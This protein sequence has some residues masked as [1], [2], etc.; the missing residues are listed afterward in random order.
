MRTLGKGVSRVGHG[1]GGKRQD[2]VQTF[3][4]PIG[5]HSAL[6]PSPPSLRSATSPKGRGKGVDEAAAGALPL[7]G[8]VPSAHTGERGLRGRLRC[9]REKTVP[10][11]T[12]LFPLGTPSAM[13]TPQSRSRSTAP[14]RGAPRAWTKPPQGA[15]PLRG[16][17]QCAHWGKGSPESDTVQ[18]GKD[19]TQCRHFFFPS[20]VTRHWHPLRPRCARPPLPKGEA[21]AWTKPPQG[22]CPF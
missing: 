14:L 7:L 19:R 9:R 8:E 3:L 13:A 22:R 10:S 6:A 16:S 17:P 5:S 20:A 4:F 18:E 15:A 21:R 2:A 1:A 11:A 12:I